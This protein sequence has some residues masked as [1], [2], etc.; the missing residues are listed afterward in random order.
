MRATRLLF[1]LAFLLAVQAGA[2]GWRPCPHHDD[3]TPGHT[4]PA[5]ATHDGHAPDAPAG[6]EHEAPCSCLDGAQC[7][8][9]VAWHAAVAPEAVLTGLVSV[10]AAPAAARRAPAR[11][12]SHFLPD[13]TAPPAV[14]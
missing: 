2:A 3:V 14:S 8:T 7:A 11:L 12:P 6:H 13:A 9:P 4:A 5:D 10:S 1:S